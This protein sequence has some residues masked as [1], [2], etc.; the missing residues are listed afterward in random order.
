MKIIF[1]F[2]LMNKIFMVQDLGPDDFEKDSSL[3]LP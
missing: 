1:V 2:Y 3:R